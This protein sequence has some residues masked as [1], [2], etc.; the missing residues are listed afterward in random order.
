MSECVELMHKPSKTKVARSS[1]STA[2]AELLSCECH[3]FGRIHTCRR[4]PHAL[5]DRV[6]IGLA[7]QRHIMQT[8]GDRQDSICRPARFTINYNRTGLALEHD[9]KIF[10]HQNLC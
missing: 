7:A 5:H 1:E 8:S 6:I 4:K 3:H 10:V 9:Q 2:E